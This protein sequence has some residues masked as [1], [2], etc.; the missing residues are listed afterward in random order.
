MGF[1]LWSYPFDRGEAQIE[2]ACS[3]HF[4]HAAF[5]GDDHLPAEILSKLLFSHDHIWVNLMLIAVEGGHLPLS[6]SRG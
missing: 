5:C 2:Q 4:R 1:W 6:F 3:L